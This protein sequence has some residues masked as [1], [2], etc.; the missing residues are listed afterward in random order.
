M[1]LCPAQ[2]Q[3]VTAIRPLKAMRFDIN[4]KHSNHIAL[5]HRAIG[6]RGYDAAIWR[7]PM[8]TQNE[9]R[10]SGQ[11]LSFLRHEDGRWNLLPILA[12]ALGLVFVIYL[13]V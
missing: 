9:A 13:I 11:S 7:C 10:P 2:W 3:R 1:K 5:T 4:S 6:C 8:A 12:G